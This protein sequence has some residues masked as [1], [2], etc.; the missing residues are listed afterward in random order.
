M[1]LARDDSG[2]SPEAAQLRVAAVDGLALTGSAASPAVPTL[3]QLTRED[4]GRLRQQAAVAL[5]AI[6]PAAGIAASALGELVIFDELDEVRDAAAS[7][8][9]RIG[10]M[11]EAALRTLLADEDPAVRRRAAA[12]LGEV[13]REQPASVA[14]LVAAL[15]DADAVV[16]ITAAESLWKTTRKADAL[17]ATILGTLTEED[18]QLRIRAYRLL[19]TLGPAARPA[20][21]A[22]QELANDP[23]PYVR[24]V[25]T[26]ALRE[27]PPT[28]AGN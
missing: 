12:A 10:E 20:R 13:L 25:A 5:G 6:G 1:Q 26:K 28:N 2:P 17:F 8:L 21:P 14:A 18:R 7:A 27:L 22:L 4:S 16:R 19:L 11:G 15:D 23:R 24:Q 3:L 9:A